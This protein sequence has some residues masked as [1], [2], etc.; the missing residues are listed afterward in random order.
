MPAVNVRPCLINVNP[1]ETRGASLT[2][3]NLIVNLARGIGPSF[4]TIFGTTF[5]FTRQVSFNLTL[6]V[7]WTLSAVQLCYLANSL[8]HDQ[9]KMEAELA[10]YAEMRLAPTPTSAAAW[11]GSPI[12]EKMA[13]EEGGGE[14]PSSAKSIFS[15]D[16]TLVSI[17]DRMTSFDVTAARESISFFQK[18]MR[19]LHFSPD[20]CAGPNSLRHH[21]S[22]DEEDDDDDQDERLSE[23]HD[24]VNNNAITNIPRH[25]GNI[26]DALS[27]VDLMKRRDM[28]MRQ[29]QELYGTQ[30]DN[31]DTEEEK[32]CQHVQSNFDQR[33]QQASSRD[34]EEGIAPTETTSLLRKA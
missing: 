34:E 26:D 11:P 2:A 27:P 18:G 14:K 25:D 28:W 33:I 19:E 3:A 5:G 32:D 20:F 15:D 13:F 31:N 10:R 17:E 21:F 9:D 4:I 12:A 8:P 1:P 16:D 29:Q 30:N 22:P 7:F 23:Y 6:G 24:E